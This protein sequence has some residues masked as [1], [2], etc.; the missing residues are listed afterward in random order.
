MEERSKWKGQFIAPGP[1]HPSIPAKGPKFTGFYLTGTS[2]SGYAPRSHWGDSIMI[3]YAML[4]FA[5]LV[6]VSAVAKAQTNETNPLLSSGIPV[7]S[8][9]LKPVGTP[10]AA[11]APKVGTPVGTPPGGQP[12]QSS[13]PP[14]YNFDLKN[15]V[16]PVSPEFLPPALRPQQKES[17][18]D[19]AF[20]KWLEAFGLAKPP[21]IKNN[22]TPGMSRRNRERARERAWW[23]D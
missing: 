19:T 16:A 22:F 1:L 6:A 3:R 20:K 12:N 14:G 4:S 13:M 9:L 18:Y 21:E 2:P 11:A 17:L 10:V 5:G 23:R 8:P 15:V 7:G